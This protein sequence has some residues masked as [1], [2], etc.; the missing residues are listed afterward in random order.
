MSPLFLKVAYSDQK[1]LISP[2][3]NNILIVMLDWKILAASFA[4]LLVVSSVL[5]GGF[6]FQDILEKV[7]E[8]MGDS[9]LSGLMTAPAAGS[10]QASVTFYP[11]SFEL[12]L[13]DASFT[14]GDARFK[15]FTGKLVANLTSDEIELI[16]GDTDFR[17]TLPL[18]T[19]SLEDISI[20]KI[21][22]EKTSFSVSSRSLETSGQ[23]VPLEVLNFHG[24]VTITG[25]HVLL[26]GNVTSVTG[27]GKEIV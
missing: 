18:T 23:G 8:W 1:R 2:W 9:P 11:D 17:A 6:G 26:D 10:R 15:A 7:N 16:Q 21:S 4:A 24:D 3:I 19:A 5:V 25:D 12:S 27:N 13:D 14:A 22:L 20:P